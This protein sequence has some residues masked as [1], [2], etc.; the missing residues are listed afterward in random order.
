MMQ[1]RLTPLFRIIFPHLTWKLSSNDKKIYLT[2]D[3]GPH[4]EITPEVLS[5]LNSFQAKAT[6]FCVG[7]NVQ[8]FESTYQ[9][10]LMKGH[11]TG[12]HT[13]N[14]LNGWKTPSSDYFQN[15]DHCAQFVDSHLFRPPY[16][17]IQ[18]SHIPYLKMRYRIIM[19]SVLT[20]DYKPKIKPEQCL[21][22]TLKQTRSGSI[23]VFHDSE[24]AR[25]NMLYTLPRFLTHFTN[26][27]YS[28]PII[29]L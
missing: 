5:I 17:R 8:K 14:H 28:F 23:V 15:I 13:H 22:R 3:D 21:R 26:L 29:P 19:W 9:K 12:N 18:P 24:K 11:R 6:F 2:F 20:G 27:G 4:P 10:I 25:E 16:G 7:E 1:N